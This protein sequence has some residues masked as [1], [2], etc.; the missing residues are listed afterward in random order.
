MASSHFAQTEGS[1]STVGPIEQEAQAG[2]VAV[3]SLAEGD[4]ALINK[5]VLGRRGR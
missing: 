4:V 1:P 5:A 3:R 2:I